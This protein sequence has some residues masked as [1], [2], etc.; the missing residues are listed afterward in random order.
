FRKRPQ[1]ADRVTIGDEV[2]QFVANGHPVHLS[3]FKKRD[4]WNVQSLS[5]LNEAASTYPVRT[6]LVFLHLLKGDADPKR[7][8]LSWRPAGQAN[9]P[10]VA[11]SAFGGGF[12]TFSEK[13][14]SCFQTCFL[15]PSFTSFIF[16][17]YPFQLQRP[18]QRITLQ[19]CPLWER[20][21]RRVNKNC[22]AS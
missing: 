1:Q 10:D 3:A 13:I 4:H 19:A 12:S 7:K 11:A 15:T 8:L 9:G 22:W 16:L 21:E 17:L 20:G 18:I 14:C 5:H 2:Q 6:L